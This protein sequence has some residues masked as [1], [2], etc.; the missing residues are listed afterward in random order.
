MHLPCDDIYQ[1]LLVDLANKIKACRKQID[2]QID[3]GEDI[4]AYMTALENACFAECDSAIAAVLEVQSTTDQQG[5][6]SKDSK[7]LVAQEE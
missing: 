3:Q 1:K 7:P 6:T 4:P 5:E 2:D